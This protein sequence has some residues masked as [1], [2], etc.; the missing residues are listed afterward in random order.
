MSLSRILGWRGARAGFPL[1]CALAGSVLAYTL[2]GVG[3]VG[4]LVGTV[5]G[6]LAIDKQSTL[7]S[8]CVTGT[9]PQL[10]ESDLDAY[11]ALGTTS[12]IALG[13]GLASTVTGVVLLLTHVEARNVARSLQLRAGPGG[14]EI[15]GAFQ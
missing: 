8:V 3:G 5:T 6:I 13:V 7:D 1:A 14:V 15:Q 11:C 4:I 2:L 12:G 9:C 10:A